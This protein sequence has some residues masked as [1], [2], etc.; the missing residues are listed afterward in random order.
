MGTIH[1]DTADEPPRS[2]CGRGT[3]SAVALLVLAGWLAAVGGAHGEAERQAIDRSPA[4][5]D[6]GLW[7]RVR[8]LDLPDYAWESAAIGLGLT[9]R[10]PWISADGLTWEHLDGRVVVVANPRDG[11]TSD[12]TTGAHE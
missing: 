7:D 9:P 6:R 12:E 8:T 4:A 3:R 10:G 1:L 5:D 2:R 11:H